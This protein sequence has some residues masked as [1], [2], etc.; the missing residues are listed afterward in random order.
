MIVIGAIAEI[1]KREGVKFLS[2]YPTTPLSETA[3]AAGIRPI[4]CRQERVGV[5]IAD[6]LSRVCNGRPVGVF[7]MQFGPGA[8]NAYSGVATAYAD[9]A[10]LL[11]FP[12]GY[13]KEKSGVQPHFNSVKSYE[14]VTKWVEQINS[15]KRVSEIMRRAFSLLKMGRPGPV[16]LELP[17]DVAEEELDVSVLNYEPVASTTSAGDARDVEAAARVLVTARNPV[18]HAGQGVLYAEASGE[19]QELAELLQ[20]PVMTTLAGKSAF[21]EDHPLSLGAGSSVMTR[22]VYHFLT[23]ADVLFGI[24]CSFTKHKPVH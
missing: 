21:C 2:C 10:P 17:T 15:A 9:S 22:P 19:L 12:M 6:G 8:E 7:A 13:P 5:G 4:V 23:K 24:G 14:S 3:A 1:L 11:L 16:M 20:A 18:I